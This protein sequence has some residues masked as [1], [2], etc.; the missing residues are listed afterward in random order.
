MMILSF[1]HLKDSR[2]TDSGDGKRGGPNAQYG[3][4]YCEASFLH[5]VKAKAHSRRC[6]WGVGSQRGAPYIRV[7]QSYSETAEP[8]LRSDNSEDNYSRHPPRTQL[9]WKKM[10]GATITESRYSHGPLR[11]L[12]NEKKKYGLHSAAKSIFSRTLHIFGLVNARTAGDS[13]R[14]QGESQ[15]ALEDRVE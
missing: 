7:H 14:N 15:G 12:V 11:C 1:G 3:T 10:L 8:P 9:R 6:W 5:G 4:L 2:K 13:I